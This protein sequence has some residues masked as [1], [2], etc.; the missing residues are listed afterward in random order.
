[1][2]VLTVFTAFKEKNYIV[3]ANEKDKAGMV[4]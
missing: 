3:F 2:G 4:R 1:M